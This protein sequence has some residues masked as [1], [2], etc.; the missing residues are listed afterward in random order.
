MTAGERRDPAA[1]DE[2]RALD[3]LRLAWGDTYHTGRGHSTWTAASKD[4]GHR[5]V[6]GDTPAALNAEIRTDQAR[7]GTL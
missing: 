2:K 1:V 7:Q 5:T 3:A 6:T 4:T